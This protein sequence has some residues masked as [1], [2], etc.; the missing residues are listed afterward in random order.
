MDG[1]VLEASQVENEPFGKTPLKREARPPTRTQ[2]RP[3]TVAG[4]TLSSTELDHRNH[5]QH[6]PINN[7]ANA[8]NFT[9]VG[10]VSTGTLTASGAATAASFAATGA[11]TGATLTI[12]RGVRGSA[13][14]WAVNG[15][16]GLRRRASS[17]TISAPQF[18][19][20][21]RGSPGAGRKTHQC[22]FIIILDKALVQTKSLSTQLS[23]TPNCFKGSL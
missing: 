10:D 17:G 16:R 8:G 6:S 19:S 7:T 14:A 11:V 1:R 2:R 22:E 18:A 21:A 12:R 3:G 23:L 9:T 4:A 20:R 13:R 5:R 15:Q